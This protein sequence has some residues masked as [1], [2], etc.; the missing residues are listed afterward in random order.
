LGNLWSSDLYSFGL[1]EFSGTAVPRG[2]LREIA[3]GSYYANTGRLGSAILQYEIGSGSTV[4]GSVEA[5]VIDS[6]AHT[7]GFIFAGADYTKEIS[8]AVT[9]L[10]AIAK[11][12]KFQDGIESNLSSGLTALIRQSPADAVEIIA[13]VARS[14]IVSSLIRCEIL[15]TLGRIE[16]PSTKGQRFA[17]LVELLQDKSPVI[18][19]AAGTS[20]AYLDDPRAIPHLEKAIQVEVVP[21]LR[22]DLEAVRAQL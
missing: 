11:E 16:S 13:E 8:A 12:E 4:F 21:S 3:Q 17:L 18:R 5:V 2:G 22:A 14:N 20:L 7:T 10:L 1:P 15:Y 9:K 19:D 6:D